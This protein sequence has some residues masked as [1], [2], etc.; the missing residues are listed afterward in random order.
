MAGTFKQLND[1]KVQMELACETWQGDDEQLLE[2]KMPA[3]DG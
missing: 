1:G 2:T 3:G